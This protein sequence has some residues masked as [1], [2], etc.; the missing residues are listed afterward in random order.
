MVPRN[1]S[2]KI[3]I[4]SRHPSLPGGIVN[5]VELLKLHL[6]SVIQIE[7]LVIGRRPEERGV[8]RGFA[9]LVG[10]AVRLAGRALSNRYGVIHL[11]TSLNEK[12]VLR[13]GIFL[14]ILRMLGT[15]RILIFFH[16]WR[17]PLE[18]RIRSNGLYRRLF[19]W[20]IGRKSCVIV[21][22]EPFK[23][24]LVAFGVATDQIEL[25]RTMFDGSAICIE[26]GQASQ[27]LD[28][29]IILFLSRFEKEKGVYELLEAF[30]RIK[31]RFP[32]AELV[33]AGGGQALDELRRRVEELGLSDR[34]KIFEY[35]RGA[36]KTDLLAEAQIFALPTY[37][38]E[39]MPIALLEAM[40]AGT[41][42]LTSRVGGI[43]YV[44]SDPDNGVVLNEVTADSVQAGLVRLLGDEAYRAQVAKRNM[45]RAWKHF[46]AGLVT[47]G[48]EKLY[49]FLLSGQEPIDA[50]PSRRPGT[51]E[52]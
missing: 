29:Q 9:R 45:E 11:N 17:P 22:A 26:K 34:V 51:T 52:S 2:M 47:R 41:A 15:Q 5:F 37:Y 14:L 21:L 18:R 48:V 31:D 46:E 7:S 10:D 40:A 42:V 28:K 43:P 32:S 13:D 6:S 12:S 20:L 35:V 8:I 27:K 38:G 16:G 39:G 33:M 49:M 50:V 1:D 19:R 44:V 36:A 3:L 25:F 4:L 30:A 24:A 23:D